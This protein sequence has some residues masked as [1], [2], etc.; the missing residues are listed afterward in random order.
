[1]L[2]VVLHNG[3]CNRLNALVSA[4]RLGKKYNKQVNIV[5]T[6]TPVR[7]CIAYHGD[8]CSFSDIF[9][10]TDI[11]EDKPVEHQRIYEF[12]YWENKDHVIDLSGDKNVFVNYALYTLIST[13]DDQSSMFKNFRSIIS[14]PQEFKLDTIGKELGDVMRN[15]LIPQDQLVEEI[16]NYEKKFFDNM[17]GIHIR[18][19]DGGFSE[20]N[21]KE[22]SKVLINQSKEWCKKE[23]NGV[24]LAT[25]DMEMYI[26]FASALGNKLVFYNPPEELCGTKSTSGNK[27]SNDKYNVLAGF[28][29]LNLLSK[30]NKYIIG[31][32]DSTFSVW[33]MI[34]NDNDDTKKYLINAVE[35][36]PSF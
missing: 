13:E 30:C 31:T 35:N 11:L 17:I 7:S 8:K 21:W 32:A 25:D 34:M 18:K 36:I 15:D 28:I 29:E 27:F 33:A 26:N 1:M 9:K 12:R 2:T 20:Y 23:N 10:N 22:M 6:Y 16:N 4:M 14:Q 19:S 24:F 5:W 3:L